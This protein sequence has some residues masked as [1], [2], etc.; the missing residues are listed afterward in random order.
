M[1]G[2]QP[3]LLAE[4]VLYRWNILEDFHHTFV[5][6]VLLQLV[7]LEAFCTVALA[8]VVQVVCWNF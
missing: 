3:T 8:I 2:A 5:A 7:V 6:E 1:L 4:R